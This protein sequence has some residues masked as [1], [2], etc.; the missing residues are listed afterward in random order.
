MANVYLKILKKYEDYNSF[1]G[2]EA[3]VKRMKQICNFAI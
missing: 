3:S 2:V 1:Q